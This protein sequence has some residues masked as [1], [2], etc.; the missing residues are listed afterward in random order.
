MISGEIWRDVP[1]VP[2]ILVSS[3]GRLMY[4]PHREPMPKGGTRPYG[5]QP[6][7]GIWN[8]SVGRFIAIIGGKSFKIHRLV[9]EAFHGPAPFEGAVVMHLDENSAN[10]RPSNLRWGTQKENMNA[11]GYLAYCH[12]R[13][14]DRSTISKSRR[15]AVRS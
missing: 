10:N 1:S 13:T 7:F 6:T 5:G 14:G 4:L 2:G 11:E 3:E 15:K 12:S 8:Q 9:A